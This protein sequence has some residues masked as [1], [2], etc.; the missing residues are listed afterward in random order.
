MGTSNEIY[1]GLN[2]INYLGS[3]SITNFDFFVRWIQLDSPLRVKLQFSSALLLL[4]IKT[5]LV[6]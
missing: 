3:L 2:E 4:W 5:F 1:L 6:G